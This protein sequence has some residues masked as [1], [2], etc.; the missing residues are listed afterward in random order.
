MAV[1]SGLGSFCYKDVEKEED[2]EE[3][4]DM[5]VSQFANLFCHSNPSEFEFQM[6]S[7]SSDKELTTT[8]PA[9]ELFYKGK[10]LPLHLPPRLQM[11]E[12]LLQ[13][14]NMD[15]FAADEFFSTPLDTSP[16]ATPIANTPFRSCNVSPTVSCD[17]SRELNP[18]DYFL[19]SN[20]T[21]QNPKKSW[22]RKL[23]M[24]KQSSIGLKL[25]ASRDYLRS[26]FGKP[27]CSDESENK[28]SRTKG[29]KKE[30]VDGNN[31]GGRHR[32]SFSYAIKRFST[33][34]A[35]SFSSSTDSNSSNNELQVHHKSI[36]TGSEIENQIQSMIAHCKMSSQKQLH[37]RKTVSDIG[38]CSLAASRIVCDDQERQVLCRG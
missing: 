16:Y 6:F 13:D 12:K 37:S 38:F 26:F 11:V 36:N 17:V 22:T 3:Y 10:L 32:R 15:T 19:D 5:E 18:E 31:G 9:D 29:K 27:S 25:K 1:D 30:K 35:S 28:I 8:S 4:I 34:N 14:K 20:S 33:T 21:D 7:S 2:Q 23:T 24:T